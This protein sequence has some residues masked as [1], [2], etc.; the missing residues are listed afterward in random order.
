MT[1]AISSHLLKGKPLV[2]T[3]LVVLVINIPLMV[4]GSRSAEIHL[5]ILEVSSG[6]SNGKQRR[7]A[8][9]AHRGSGR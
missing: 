1:A 5:N 9:V 7:Q 3:R 6:S 4:L 2:W 8:T